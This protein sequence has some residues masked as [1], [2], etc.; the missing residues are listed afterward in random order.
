MPLILSSSK[1]S[2]PPRPDIV[3]TK[4]VDKTFESSSKT[5]KIVQEPAIET[6][7][8]TKQL[9]KIAPEPQ[10]RVATLNSKQDKPIDG[11]KAPF[12][13][14][15][16]GTT[17]ESFKAKQASLS[18]TPAPAS[19]ALE[20]KLPEHALPVEV[21]EKVNKVVA[22]EE[23]EVKAP[24]ASSITPTFG[25]IVEKKS[26]PLETIGSANII[27]SLDDVNFDSFSFGLKQMEDLRAHSTL[28][29]PFY[30]ASQAFPTV[31]PRFDGG[32]RADSS[33]PSLATSL[34]LGPSGMPMTVGP[35][36]SAE[37]SLFQ[38]IFQD[39]RP[40]N[41]TSSSSSFFLDTPSA[42]FSDSSNYDS[43]SFFFNNL[44]STNND[45]G[46]SSNMSTSRPISV[47][48]GFGLSET[49]SGYFRDSRNVGGINYTFDN[50][51]LLPQSSQTINSLPYSVDN[52]NSA[53]GAAHPGAYM[54][55]GISSYDTSLL[56]APP[57]G[58][59]Y[60][61]ANMVGGITSGSI[62]N[63]DANI[64]I[65]LSCECTSLPSN[66]IKSL[67]IRTNYYDINSA[68]ANPDQ[69]ILRRAFSNPS[70]WR[71]TLSV[72][73]VMERL[74]YSY[75]VVDN[76]GV[77]WVEAEGASRQVVLRSPNAELVQEDFLSML[78]MAH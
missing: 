71:A 56:M 10:S 1:R 46:T 19:P 54:P 50:S 68:N 38:N 49:D 59:G 16:R 3:T 31:D 43:N 27:G 72:P 18:N 40:A 51:M 66:K 48:P 28:L 74:V 41:S 39:S 65:N 9:E 23:L 44:L 26:E 25:N 78:K 5:L 75:I 70:L 7:A 15:K 73:I 34:N 32:V 77:E 30:Q 21:D 20:E 17:M 69:Q 36:S 22:Q 76:E 60:A 53:M 47:P 67:R 33:I 35:S 58:R 6:V 2:S 4:I 37:E 62:A 64:T 57:A 12:T 61:P 63:A 52:F 29:D 11:S 55:V 8:S 45:V 14:L 13:I 42:S 24:I